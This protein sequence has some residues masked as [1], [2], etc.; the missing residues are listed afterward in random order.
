MRALLAFDKFKDSLTAVQACEIAADALRAQRPEWEL[1]LAPLSDGGDGFLSVL[2]AA[3]PRERREWTVL[4]PRGS[5]TTGPV[6]FVRWA[7]IPAQARSILN[8][9]R[10]LSLTPDATVAIVEMAAVSGLALLP[11]SKR[12]P[13]RTTSFGTGQL[14]RHA[15]DS[16]ADA[17][18]LGVGGSATHDLGLG[19]LAALGLRFFDER[20]SEITPP[21][22][23]CWSRITHVAWSV[24]ERFPPILIACDVK[25]QLLGPD[26]AAAVFG[27][28]KGLHAADI[29]RLDAASRRM[30]ALLCSSLGRPESLP[31]TAGAG[32]A[33][34]VAF[35]LMAGAGAAF[36]PGA[37]LVAA[38]LR[39]DERIESADVV[40]TGEG[41]FDASSW[42]GK[43]PGH[44]V[45]R[46]LALKKSVQVFAGS[47]GQIPAEVGAG[48]SATAIS[49]PDLELAEALN[50]APRL[51][52]ERIA[53]EFSK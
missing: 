47:L 14:L 4:G 20:V 50:A 28:Q 5:P 10:A 37:E 35:G 17:I 38:W 9:T 31:E 21:V 18:L 52:R 49:P 1:D 19:C 27:P 24:N 34:G 51:L 11:P 8:A 3:L 43:G 16:G 36:A 13:W 32:A 15:M 6:V 2:T 33:G 26:G 41:R 42:T 7:D 53:R 45:Q 25:N 12:D 48:L 22:P 40:I 23:C 39:L 44:V 30:A 29:A 46:A